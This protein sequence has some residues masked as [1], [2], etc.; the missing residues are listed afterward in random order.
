MVIK[1]IAILFSGSG[2]NLENILKKL[3]NKVFGDV[4]IEVALTLC[5]KESVLG[6]E[7]SRKYGIEPVI[8]LNKDFSTREEF[9]KKLVEVIKFHDIDLVVLAGFM[10]I[11]T[12]AFT[13]NVTAINLHPSLL[14]LF[15]GANAIKDSFEADVSEGGVSVH[16]VNAELD[17]GEIILQQSFKKTKGMSFTEFEDKIHK[18][19]YE[20]LPQAIIKLLTR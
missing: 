17:G 20:I 8:V 10:R 13:D 11:L 4:K 2:T 12:P 1:K 19:E 5:N 7:R 3:H 18:I 16:F 9:D 14:P 15:K 6:I